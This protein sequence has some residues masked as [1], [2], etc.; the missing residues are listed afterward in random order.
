VSG[1]TMQ[2]QVAVQGTIYD[3]VLTVT[4]R[5]EL[6]AA[7]APE[8]SGYLARALVDRPRLLVFDLSGVGFMDC[9]A[10]AAIIGTSRALPGRPRP[11]LCNPRPVVRRLLSLTG[12]DVQCTI[13]PESGTGQVRR[14]VIG[15]RLSRSAGLSSRVCGR[16]GA[17]GA[18]HGPC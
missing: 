11:V 13:R 10:A 4:V 3:G 18:G 2:G 7:T 5:G 8:L 12:L 16:A 6:D 14:P 17:V 1:Q 9:A 15:S